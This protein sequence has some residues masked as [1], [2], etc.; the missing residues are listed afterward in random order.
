MRHMNA[1]ESHEKQMRIGAFMGGQGPKAR[2]I[3]YSETVS[4]PLKS[5]PSGLNTIPDVVYFTD[6]HEKQ[7]KIGAFIVEQGAKARTIA[8][9]ETATPSLK[10]SPPGGNMIDVVYPAKRKGNMKI[11]MAFGGTD[12]KAAIT[13]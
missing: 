10:S 6:C 2:S 8:Y 3:A 9:S 11:V 5:A 13:D 12:S 4:P 7:M 1:K